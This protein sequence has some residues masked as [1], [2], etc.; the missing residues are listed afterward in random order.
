MIKFKMFKKV[1]FLGCQKMMIIPTDKFA[2]YIDKENANQ[3]NDKRYIYY[4]TTV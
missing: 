1:D 4:A 2:K 3:L